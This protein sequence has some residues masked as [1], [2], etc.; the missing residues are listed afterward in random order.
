MSPHDNKKMF[1]RTILYVNVWCKLC[2]EDEGG[3]WFPSFLIEGNDQLQ[4]VVARCL[5]GSHI[6]CESFNWIHTVCTCTSQHSLALFA[7]LSIQHGFCLLLSWNFEV[8]KTLEGW[9][10]QKNG[11]SM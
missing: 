5:V 1:N 10:A 6:I 9:D 2:M 11:L 8:V 3:G 4:H 7:S